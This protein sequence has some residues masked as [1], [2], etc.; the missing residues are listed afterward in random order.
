MHARETRASESDEQ[1]KAKLEQAKLHNRETRASEGCE[2][3]EVE[4]D[5]STSQC[6]VGPWTN[7]DISI[8]RQA[9][10]VT[11]QATSNPAISL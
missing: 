3:R 6:Y 4:T 1:R 9:V 5:C 2:Q 11:V 7:T 8:Q 10:Q